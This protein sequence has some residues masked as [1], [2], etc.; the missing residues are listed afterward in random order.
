MEY[1][2]I[3][4]GTSWNVVFEENWNFSETVSLTAR[5]LGNQKIRPEKTPSEKLL[6]VKE[7]ASHLDK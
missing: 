7:F 1:Q 5:I 6:A 4:P 2:K 3:G